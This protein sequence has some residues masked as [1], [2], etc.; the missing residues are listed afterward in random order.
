MKKL[1]IGLCLLMATC[2][3]T[4]QSLASESL[5]GIELVSIPSGHFLMGSKKSHAS[6]QFVH[7][8][9]I[10]AFKMMTHE[11]TQKLWKSVMGSNPSQ[12]KDDM[13][14][15]ENV[16]WNEIQAFINKLNQSTGQHFRLPSEA[17]WEYAARAGTTSKFYF[18]NDDLKLCQYGNVFDLSAKRDG[19]QWEVINCDDGY[20]MKTSPV[21]LFLSNGFGLYDMHGNVWE[22]VED[23]YNGRYNNAPRDGSAWLEGNCSQRVARGGGWSS[24]PNSLRSATRGFHDS[25]TRDKA[26]GFRLAHD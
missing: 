1:L 22:F 18:G 23:C 7:K 20:G 10:K 4:T 26:T 2:A 8:V 9:S 11:V 13:R 14:P 16:S 24:K 19:Y 12:F 3:S 17:E 25:N 6:D 21:A 15:V 5:S